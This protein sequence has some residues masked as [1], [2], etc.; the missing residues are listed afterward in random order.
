MNFTRGPSLNTNVIKVIETTST[1]E[2]WKKHYYLQI[3]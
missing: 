2:K 3:A 1:G